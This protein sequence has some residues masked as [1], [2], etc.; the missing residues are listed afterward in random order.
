MENNIKDDPKYFYIVVLITFGLIGIIVW[1]IFFTNYEPFVE[2]N[3]D[4]ENIPQ[5]NF[6]FLDS[7]I[8][9]D[10]NSFK[11]ADEPLLSWNGNRD[12]P[13]MEPSV[14]QDENVRDWWGVFNVKLTLTE[15]GL[16]GAYP[17]SIEGDTDPDLILFEGRAYSISVESEDNEECDF[18]IQNEEGTPLYT[19]ETETETEL[20]I[21]ATNEILN[22]SCL[23]Q[24]G[25]ITI[26][27]NENIES[28]DFEDRF[29]EEFESL[30]EKLDS[31][32]QSIIEDEQQQKYSDLE[33]RFNQLQEEQKDSEIS[34]NELFSN[35]NELE[36]DIE[37]EM[38]KIEFKNNLS[39][40]I[41][42]EEIRERLDNKEGEELL[43]EAKNVSEEIEGKINQTENE[44]LR[45]RVD[46]IYQNLN[47]NLDLIE[48]DYNNQ[49]IDQEKLSQ[50]IVNYYDQFEE[51]INRLEI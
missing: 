24:S 38:E 41:N 2:S 21:R 25:Q 48:E 39:E 14:P 34:S 8:F 45:Q 33:E 11:R 22:Y 5:I 44:T 37:K 15:E 30:K 12:N 31:L 43:S 23:N 1:Q 10:L 9:K 3:N 47:S 49:E 27:E 6:P 40:L 18:T 46:S 28:E 50:E 13:F 17:P 36:R 29:K 19:L 7:F 20:N 16:K 32:N 26:I 35:I 51:A 42:F 4:V